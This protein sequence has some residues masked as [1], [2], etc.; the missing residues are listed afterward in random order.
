MLEQ[1]YALLGWHVRAGAKCQ[2]A[3]Y[4]ASCLTAVLQALPG[5][6]ALSWP[7]HSTPTPSDRLRSS[8]IALFVIHYDNEPGKRGGVMP[9]KRCRCS[10]QHCAC[11]CPDVDYTTLRRPVGPPVHAHDHPLCVSRQFQVSFLGLVLCG[12]HGNLMV[13]NGGWRVTDDDCRGPDGGCKGFNWGLQG[14]LKATSNFRAPSIVLWFCHTLSRRFARQGPLTP[15]L[16][17]KR[18]R[19][20]SSSPAASGPTRQ[21]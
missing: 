21:C 2:E 15:L 17:C 5:P 19:E 13:P 20:G 14:A 6:I 12:Y 18:V 7:C 4:P 1:G 10:S 16:G 8:L 9:V 3:V 11:V